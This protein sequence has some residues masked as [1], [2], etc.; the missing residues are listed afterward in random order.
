MLGTHSVIHD[1]VNW[2]L[3]NRHQMLT[4]K[5][6]TTSKYQIGLFMRYK[7]QHVNINVEYYTKQTYQWAGV[8]WTCVAGKGSAKG[9]CIK[10]RNVKCITKSASKRRSRK[11]SQKSRVRVDD[12]YCDFNKKPSTK[13]EF[14]CPT[15]CPKKY[16]IFG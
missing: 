15:G 2:K 8:P 3:T 10:Q 11:K 14:K 5:G 6:P 13:E 1:G 12:K 16:G 9:S 7:G 4:A